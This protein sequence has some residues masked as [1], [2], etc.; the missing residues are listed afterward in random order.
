M[1]K[2]SIRTRLLLL[3]GAVT[4]IALCIGAARL[5][6]VSR[7]IGTLQQMYE[8]RAQALQTI[9]TINELVT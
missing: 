5:M 4:V 7:S 1:R 8:G 9:S 2:S 6:D 3:T